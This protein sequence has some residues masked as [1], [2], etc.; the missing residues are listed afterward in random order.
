MTRAC[1]AATL[2][3]LGRF[4]DAFADADESLRLSPRFLVAL[5]NALV[6]A[7][8]SNDPTSMRARAEQLKRA[9]ADAAVFGTALSKNLLEDPDMEN[10]RK[11]SAFAAVMPELARARG[12]GGDPKAWVV[13]LAVLSLTLLA[14]LLLS[15]S[16]SLALAAMF[17]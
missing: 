7:S 11:S 4:G 17:C 3:R 6:A 8:A 16:P 10:F 1:R 5:Y 15:A 9:H 13:P 14:L 2:T 12:N